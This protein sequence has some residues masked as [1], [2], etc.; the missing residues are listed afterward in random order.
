VRETSELSSRIVILIVVVFLITVAVH[1]LFPILLL[2]LRS[3]K[4]CSHLHE[5]KQLFS[6]MDLT[7]YLPEF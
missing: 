3:A 1:L 6:M 2:Y 5:M 7:S 4:T